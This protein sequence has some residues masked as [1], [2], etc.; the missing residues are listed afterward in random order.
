MAPGYK[1]LKEWI[2]V[3]D[4]GFSLRN[5]GVCS[6]HSSL[7][8]DSELDDHVYKFVCKG[9]SACSCKGWEQGWG[10]IKT[11]NFQGK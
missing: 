2:Y 8:G 1:S 9:D 11:S 6:A 5:T 3:S 10:G 4:M 7:D